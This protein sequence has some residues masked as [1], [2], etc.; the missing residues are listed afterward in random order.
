MAQS[1]SNWLSEDGVLRAWLGAGLTILLAA[2]VALGIHWLMWRVL[3]RVGGAAGMTAA[4][5]RTAA[6]IA[7]PTLAVQFVV[8]TLP[9]GRGAREFVSHAASL[10]MILAI[11]WAAIGVVGLGGDLITKR[12][13]ID[14]ADNLQARRIHTQVRILGLSLSVVIGVVGF[15]VALMT[16][17]QVKQ[18]GTSLLAS[19]GIAGIILGLAARP[20]VANLIA[21]VQL[22]FTQPIRIDDVV[23]VEGEWGRVEEF[24]ATYVVIRIWDERRLVV[25]LGYFLEHPFQNW[26]RTSA[27]ILGS[28]FLWVDYTVPVDRIREEV[29]RLVK[30]DADWDGRVQVVQVTNTSPQGIEVR[31]LVSAGDASKAWNLRCRVRERLVD[32]VQRE[33]PGSLPR[34][35]AEIQAASSAPSR[36]P[37]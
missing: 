8:P 5:V 21:G 16:F 11:T 30:D 14:V 26:T 23:I 37:P 36:A 13:R 33:H 25:P 6:A 20:L 1:A 18:V 2:V 32:F 22:M 34:T 10:L 15:A 19:A 35:R 17:P 31:V 24:T 9:V 7:L 12:H 29:A 4:R 28:V 27:D 3:R